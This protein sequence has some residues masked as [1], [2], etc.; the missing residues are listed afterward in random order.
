MFG[1]FNIFKRKPKKEKIKPVIHKYTYSLDGPDDFF[2]EFNALS[3]KTRLMVKMTAIFKAK[4][5]FKEKTKIKIITYED[6]IEL[7][8]ITI[9]TYKN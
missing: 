9:Y 3:A 5:L 2:K 1:I 6:E 8:T 4:K 7:E